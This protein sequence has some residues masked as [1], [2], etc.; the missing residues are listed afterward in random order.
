MNASAA[1][2]AIGARFG[3][4]EKENRI[5]AIIRSRSLS[6]ILRAM[7]A[8]GTLLELG[9]GVGHEAVAVSERLGAR[10]VAVEPAQSLA[11]AISGEAKGRSAA[12]EVD[13]R[14]A[15]TAL[16]S[17][18]AQGRTFDGAWSSFA[19][20]YEAP[21]SELRPLLAAVLR[22]RAPLVL[23]LRNPW[24]LAEPWSIPLRASGRYRHK[25]GS[26]RVPIRHYSV[27][28]AR[29]ALSPAF[30]LRSVQ[31]VPAIVPPPRYG[32]AWNHLGRG[33]ALIERADAA[34][35]TR[36]PFRALGDHTLFLFERS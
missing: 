24:C 10:V 19:L 25:V 14:D 32:R 36:A 8:G 26:A 7:P 33:A 12:L 34:L 30:A 20:G 2:N 15:R 18:A 28:A 35:A 27:G 3:R 13:V 29:A 9:A 6:A 4:L 1:Y 11:A 16:A 23:T 5:L 22:P 21:L 17:L 31:A